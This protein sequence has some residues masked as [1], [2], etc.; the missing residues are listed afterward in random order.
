M[1]LINRLTFNFGKVAGIHAHL[2]MAR[3]NNCSDVYKLY[4]EEE[5][6]EYED[7]I[8]TA[9]EKAK[10]AAEEAVEK[11][12]D[13]IEEELEDDID[14]SVDKSIDTRFHS[15]FHIP[16]I[17]IGLIVCII[18]L[19]GLLAYVKAPTWLKVK[20]KVWFTEQY[21]K[22]RDEMANVK[23]EVSARVEALLD[24]ATK[25]V[26]E[27]LTQIRKCKTCKSCKSD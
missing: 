18:V 22:A 12:K 9:V 17:V 21:P 15:T 11:A 1:V 5:D 10:E 2:P 23:T 20:A 4:Q 25:E 7:L 24:E 6:E 16:L 27:K 14:Q 3:T 26:Q 8:N 19:L 13:S